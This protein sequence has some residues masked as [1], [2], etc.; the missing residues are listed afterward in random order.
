MIFLEK[1]LS[2]LEKYVVGSVARNAATTGP[3][4][5]LYTTM[6][7]NGSGNSRTASVDT[8]NRRSHGLGTAQEV[9]CLL[10]SHLLGDLREFLG[11]R[12]RGPCENPPA[13]PPAFPNDQD[14]TSD[15]SKQ[16][17]SR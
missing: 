4:C 17:A 1:A 7:G 3:T 16:T 6:I 5:S 12:R 9:A 15:V 13:H 8:L 11:R 14:F 10:S 2:L